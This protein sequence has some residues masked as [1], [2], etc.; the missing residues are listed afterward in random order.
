MLVAVNNT[1]AAATTGGLTSVGART[2]ALGGYQTLN[3]YTAATGGTWDAANAASWTNF[4]PG[5]S[6]GASGAIAQFADGAGTGTGANTLTLNTT[7]NVQGIQFSSTVAGHNYAINDA[8]NS[9][10]S[11]ILDNTGNNASATIADSSAS[12]NSN[13]INVPI[14]L[15]S[16]LA[17]SVT[18]AANILTIDAPVS[19]TG[20]S[21][22]KSG[23]GTL[24]LT[25]ANTYTGPTTIST[26]TLQLGNGGASGSLSGT[27]GITN[28]GMLVVNRNNPFLGSVDLHNAG[29]TGSGG[30]AQIGSGLTTLDMPNSFTGGTVI[31][32]GQVSA[33][34]SGSLGSGT[35]GT[36][37]VAITNAATLLLTGTGNLDR[38]RNDATINLGGTV[39]IAS[40]S[41]EG[42]A[43]TVSGGTNS[44][45]GSA[46]GLGALTLSA[47]S[48]L[49]FDS[50]GGSTLLV[51]NSFAAA[52]FT[53]NITGY[54][55]TTFD[56][57]SNSGS[58]TDD[59]LVFNSNLTPAQLASINFG[60]GITATEIDLGN[61]YFEVGQAIPEPASLGVPWSRP[62][63]PHRLEE[64][65]P[66]CQSRRENSTR[67]I[68][69]SAHASCAGRGLRRI[70]R[71]MP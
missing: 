23:A 43:A 18:N 36:A 29:I 35:S 15:A 27:T 17:V 66:V 28:N 62:P 51:F 38:L 5:S 33:S 50:T 64:P 8:G 22:T 30:F 37:S 31:S 49:D 19:G 4:D 11:I 67:L 9:T 55:N 46:F 44:G 1:A 41:S 10:S 13:A 68:S 69:A 42:T 47:N 45:T 40:G 6:T 48:T 57:T 26:G 59:R 25:G 53:L 61:G 21:V 52:G 58:A 70:G 39:A 2:V 24:V 7:R 3:T 34:V 12:G 32:N 71:I 20:K 65:S 60:S 54:A 63:R 16:N 56:G 14:T